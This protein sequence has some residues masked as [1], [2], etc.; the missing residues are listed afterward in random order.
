MASLLF[1]KLLVRSGVA[2][3]L[4]SVK[5]LTDGGGA[6]LRCYSDRVLAAPHAALADA[7]GF[8][9]PH[10]S[11]VI[12]LASGCP[13][14]DAIASGSTKLPVH[15]RGFPPVGGLAELRSAVAD[16]YRRDHGLAFHPLDEVLITH[17]IAGAFATALNALINPGHAVVLFDPSSPLYSL[18]LAGRR[19]RIR[20]VRTWTDQGRLR[21]H[22]ADLARALRGARMMVLNTPANPTGA[23][24]AAEDLEQ[25]AWW[26]ERRNVLIFS[27][28]A[29]DRYWYRNKI[30]T[31]A[32]FAK[33]AARTLTAGSV[34]ASHALTSA[35]VGW[36]AG[37]RHLLR[38]SVVSAALESPF[39]ATLCQQIA[40]GALRQEPETFERVLSEFDS[41]RRYSVERLRAMGFGITLPSG[42]FFIWL[43]VGALKVSGRV[44]C[45]RLMAQHHVALLPGDLFG[46]SGSGYVRL[47]YA[48]EDG[49]LQEGLAR[50]AQFVH[51]QAREPT[52]KQAA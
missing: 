26:A 49:R 3:F 33:A 10:P 1:R 27:D 14:F 29:Y 37:P 31:I 6:W 9:T 51:D 24:I 38:A 19:A 11:E 46:P 4:P 18:A 30:A 16:K 40:L 42:A 21:F 13:A 12:N 41:R 25:I 34:S 7:A 47:S 43:P 45:E 8:L 52:H 39:V 17:G 15:R 23:A 50:L 32:A 44:F 48:G 36:M 5:R 22:V 35:R 28:E 2:R 20:W